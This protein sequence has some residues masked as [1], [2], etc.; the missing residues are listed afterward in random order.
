MSGNNGLTSLHLM[1]L[2][3]LE[4]LYT[5]QFEW[6]VELDPLFLLGFDW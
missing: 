2:S 4:P 1:F 5:F 6:Q 3:K